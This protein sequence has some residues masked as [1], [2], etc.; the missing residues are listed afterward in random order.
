[1]PALLDTLPDAPDL[2]FDAIAKINAPNWTSGRIALLGDAAWGV[3]LGGMGVGTGLVGAHLLAGELARAGADHRTAFTAYEQRMRAY[4][5]R[6]QKGANPGKFLAPA[7][8]RGLALR[9][10]LLAAGVVQRMLLS[11]TKN[12][13]TDTDLPD[14][15]E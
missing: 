7:T 3:T 2:Y 5:G 12:L 13:A 11:G 14:Y 15:P 10:R 8:R 4:A 9:N 1:V 6:W